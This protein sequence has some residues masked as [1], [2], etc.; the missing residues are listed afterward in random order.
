MGRRS[1]LRPEEEPVHGRTTPA[2][3]ARAAAEDVL[4]LQQSAG[5]RA[6]SAMLA[7]EP[8][9]ADAKA[10]PA[11]AANAMRPARARSW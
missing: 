9:P 5:N 6:V 7:R 3:P 1:A 2:P 4:A 11:A 10:P 8:A